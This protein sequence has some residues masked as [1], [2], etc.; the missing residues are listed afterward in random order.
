MKS[1]PGEVG[2]GKVVLYTP[3]DERHRHTGNCRQIVDGVLM[4]AMSGLAICEAEAEGAYYL[5][6]CDKNWQPLTDTWHQSLDDAKR[7][8]EFE[9]EGVSAT[10]QNPE[11]AS[12]R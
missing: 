10:W 8:A 11:G 9:Y 7:Q 12:G 1:I 5:L 4:G 6:G 3:I 2:G